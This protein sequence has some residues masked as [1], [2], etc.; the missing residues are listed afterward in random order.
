MNLKK[1][2][3][4]SIKKR[5]Y[6]RLFILI[7]EIGFVIFFLIPLAQSLVFAFSKVRFDGVEN[8]VEFCGLDNFRYI[9]YESEKYVDN[10]V[11]SIA[12]FSYSIPLVMSLSLIVA[13]IL[14][15]KFAG[16]TL[17][18]AIFFLPVIISTGVIIEFMREDAMAQKLLSATQNQGSMYLRG[19]IDFSEVMSGLGLPAGAQNL[20]ISLVNHIYELLWNCGIPIVLFMAGLQSIPEQLYD[21]SKVEGATKWEEFWYVTFPML[22]GTALLTLVYIAID[23]FIDNSNSVINQAFTSMQQQVYDKSSA[24]LWAYFTIVGGGLGLVVMLINRYLL[25]KWE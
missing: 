5:T 2:K 16:R 9:F 6:G 25:K 19:L 12:S 10:L 17:M 4:F 24:M 18:R 23:L 14:N 7:W 21:V 3:D 22:S 8:L 20:L 13:L 11:D 15:R 1:I